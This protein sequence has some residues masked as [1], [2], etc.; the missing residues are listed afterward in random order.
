MRVRLVAS[1]ALV[2]T[3]I[4]GTFTRSA[5]SLDVPLPGPAPRPASATESE[6]CARCHREI[7]NEWRASQHHHAWDDDYFV[8]SYALEPTA[9]CRKCHAPTADPAREPSPA[10]Q[11]EGIGCSTCHVA[12]ASVG[13]VGTHAM[14]SKKDAHAVLGDARLATDAACGACHQFA[15]PAPQGFVAGP[16]Q[17][18]LGEHKR[19][20]A[21]ATPCQ[22]CHM[23]K[24]KGA[25]GSEHM[26]HAFR[27]Q[28]DKAT[29]ARAVVVKS[30]S[31]EVGAAKL[32]LAPGAI[33]HAFP[34]GDLYRRAELR[35][36]P[37]DARDQATGAAA[38]VA[39]ER[40][41]TTQRIGDG[42]SVRTQATDTRLSSEQSFSL[43][44]PKATKRARFQI[45]WQQM[46]ASLA[47]KI[48]WK[49][50]D[51]EVVIA[52]GIVTR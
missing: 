23:P 19:S 38:I 25:N 34:T 9:F 6:A 51:H 42:Q 30:A 15:F 33:G 37:I 20:H 4:L 41:F 31:L 18:T 3:T 10:A 16:M 44:L 13:V 5:G 39:F 21:P 40:T 27:V 12:T 49:L 43:A 47:T 2:F 14:A 26:S 50:S 22:G 8:R 32:T 24:I 28:G 35:V 36:T 45:V 29:L 46:P 7:A 1:F 48:G 52:E 11:A 17:D